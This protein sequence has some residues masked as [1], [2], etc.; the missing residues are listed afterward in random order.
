MTFPTSFEWVGLNTFAPATQKKLLELLRRLKEKNVN[1]LTILV[2]GK[3]GVGKSST[4]NSIIGERASEGLG[5]VMVSCSVSGFTLN[6]IDTPGLVNGGH[7]NDQ[8]LEIIKHSLLNKT[9]DILLYVDRLDTYRMDKLDELVMGAI[10]DRFG[11]EI[12]NMALIV[13][14][15]A[16]FSPQDGLPYDEFVLQKS[17]ALLKALRQGA[18]LKEED[19]T[20]ASSIPFVLVE[21]SGRCNKNEKGEEV[22]PNGTAWTPN[23]LQTITEVAMRAYKSIY[24]DKNLI[25]QPDCNQRGKI[26]ILFVFALEC[27]FVIKPI[28]EAI[29]NDIARE[30]VLASMHI[31]IFALK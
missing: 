9:I 26:L 8:A 17:E 30:L 5:P 11:K 4:V 13:L 10:T 29:K 31:Y 20:M 28:K 24:V 23:L 22:L 18:R 2:M 1:K 7:I 19:D 14:T 27:L 15:H 25:E 12:W 21:N 3:C 6:I 16:Q